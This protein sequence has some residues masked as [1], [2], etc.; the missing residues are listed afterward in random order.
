M[1]DVMQMNPLTLDIA[2]SRVCL[3]ATK[4]KKGVST[5]ASERAA[6]SELSEFL[7]HVR[8]SGNRASAIPS[9]LVPDDRARKEIERI[10]GTLVLNRRSPLVPDDAIDSILRTLATLSENHAV[11]VPDAD[12]LIS[13]LQ[14]IGECAASEDL[15]TLSI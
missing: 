1:V 9:A 2:V 3:A 4:A 11:T 7:I 6:A 13:Q 10:L 15:P 12:R 8:E 14:L 5:T